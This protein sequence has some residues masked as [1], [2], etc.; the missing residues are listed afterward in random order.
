MTLKPSKGNEDPEGFVK[1]VCFYARF[2][3]EWKVV[4]R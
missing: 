1:P 4:E 3:A 2:D